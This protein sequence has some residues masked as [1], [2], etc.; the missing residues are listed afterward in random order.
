MLMYLCGAR[1][2]R[3][4]YFPLFTVNKMTP[5]AAMAYL[6]YGV[7][8]ALPVVLNIMEDIK[9]RSLRSGI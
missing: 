2:V 9:W 6:L 1:Q 5:A 4:L 3:I 7:L 8:C